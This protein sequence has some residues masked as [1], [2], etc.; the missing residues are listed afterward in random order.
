MQKTRPGI[1]HNLSQIFLAYVKRTTDLFRLA[2]L[3]S[4]LAIKTLVTLIVLALI[5]LI[6]LITCWACVLFLLGLYFISLHFSL[7]SAAGLVTLINMVMLVAIIS[8]MLIIKKNLFFPALRRQ[9]QHK[10]FK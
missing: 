5:A 4:R 2:K 6:I 7:L 8:W 10:D 3:E 9:I 1:L